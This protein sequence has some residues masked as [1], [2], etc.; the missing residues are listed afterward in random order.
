MI[1]ELKL[2]GQNGK[3]V[4]NIP[5]TKVDNDDLLIRII[6]EFGANTDLYAIL[7]NG[8]VEKHIKIKNK[9]FKIEKELLKVGEC[10]IIIVAKAGDVEVGRYNCVPILI[11]ELKSDKYIIDE[12]ESFKREI[13]KLRNDYETLKSELTHTITNSIK[14]LIIA[15]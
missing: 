11:T 2:L 10:Y 5:Y 3:F 1:K 14:S 12:I 6:T 15:E 13:A 9:Q 8:K 4:D 7:K